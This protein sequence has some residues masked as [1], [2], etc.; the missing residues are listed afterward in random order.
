MQSDAM[1]VT[2]SGDVHVERDGQTVKLENG[3]VIHESDRILTDDDSSAMIKFKDNTE[4]ELG[5]NTNIKI[6]DFSY[7]ENEPVGFVMNLTH[8]LMRSVSGEIVKQNPDAF[9]IVMPMSTVG[10]RGTTLLHRV[11]EGS[12]THM[13]IVLGKGHDVVITSTSGQSAIITEALQGITLGGLSP[14]GLEVFEVSPEMFAPYEQ[15]FNMPQFNK[16]DTESNQE[17]SSF[18]ALVLVQ[19][20]VEATSDKIIEVLQEVIPNISLDIVSEGLVGSETS[21]VTETEVTDLLNELFDTIINEKINEV[22]DSNKPTLPTPEAEV[23]PEVAPNPE[24]IF[25]NFATGQNGEVGATDGVDIITVTGTMSSGQILTVGG[26]DVLTIGT[27]TSGYIDLGDG[28]DKL[29]IGSATGGTIVLGAGDDEVR[30]TGSIDRGAIN[31]GTGTN[32]VAVDGEM[33]GTRIQGSGDSVDAI[34]V[35]GSMTS[36]VINLGGGDDKVTIGKLHSGTIDLGDDADNITIN[37]VASGNSTIELGN[38]TAADV[39]TF[40]YNSSFLQGDH[41]LT[42]EDFDRGDTIN[43]GNLLSDAINNGNVSISA[44]GENITITDQNS[45]SSSFGKEFTI[46]FEG[47]DASTINAIVASISSSGN[48]TFS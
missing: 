20:I 25:A 17:T 40:D 31:L 3:D 19:D 2:H 4:I 38:D 16:L 45:V 44:S 46:V 18:F 27:L 47:L 24:K 30:I 21:E 36:S 34:V 6:S 22:A 29:N 42:L 8:G 13:V 14:K 12:E 33:S 7:G 1:L 26:N 35:T 9:K 28:N 37:A 41:T 10:I 39:L 5:E 32:S 11:E 48:Y 15:I 23:V 43:F